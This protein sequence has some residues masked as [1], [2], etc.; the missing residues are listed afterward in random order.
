MLSPSSTG[1]GARR[2]VPDG[3]F[4]GGPVGRRPAA[5]VLHHRPGLVQLRAPRQGGPAV[6]DDAAG[7]AG[8]Q[9]GGHGAPAPGQHR[10]GRNPGQGL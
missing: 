6:R 2:A 8:R 7:G 1:R 4:R 10:R 3:R 5:G 9:Q